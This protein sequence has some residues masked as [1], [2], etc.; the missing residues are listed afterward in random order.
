MA[1]LT[2]TAA[3]LPGEAGEC[4]FSAEDTSPAAPHQDGNG[5]RPSRLFLEALQRVASQRHDHRVATADAAAAA[6]ADAASKAAVAAAHKRDTERRRAES[7]QDE[8]GDAFGSKAAPD[9]ALPLKPVP[10]VG[11]RPQRRGPRPSSASAVTSVLPTGTASAAM[12]AH[13]NW[14][15]LETLSGAATAR[16]PQPSLRHL[17]R[18]DVADMRWRCGDGAGDDADPARGGSNTGGGYEEMA[19]PLASAAPSPTAAA[20]AAVVTPAEGTEAATAAVEATLR[21]TPRASPPPKAQPK[22]VS[23]L[24]PAIERAHFLRAVQIMRAGGA[25]RDLPPRPQ[26]A[27]ARLSG[28]NSHDRQCR[29]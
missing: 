20:A 19:S 17:A 23:F 14:R 21:S 9:A 13:L 11:P 10:P 22:T 3:R 18:A 8:V 7:V 29:R 2:P 24:D 27:V 28:G 26:S 1:T 4:S 16:V 15:G 25:G 6:T 12:T 5:I